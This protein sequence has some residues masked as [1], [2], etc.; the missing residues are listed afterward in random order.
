MSQTLIGLNV[1]ITFCIVSS[2]SVGLSQN[3]KRENTKKE[4]LIIKSQ[5]D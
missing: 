5:D 1:D 4:D 3:K 2:K